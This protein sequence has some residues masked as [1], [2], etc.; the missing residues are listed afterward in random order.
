M[1]TSGLG[2]SQSNTGLDGTFSITN[3]P[4][5]DYQV[6]FGDP[7]CSYSEPNL[8]PGWF[9]NAGHQPGCH[10]GVG[11]CGAR[12]PCSARTTLTTG[13][14]HH[15]HSDRRRAAVRWPAY[16]WRRRRPGSA[17]ARLLGDQRRHGGYSIIDLPAGHYR[18]QF[19]SGCGAAGYKTQWWKDKPTGQAATIVTVTAAT[20]TT[21]IGAGAAEVASG[22]GAEADAA[23]PPAKAAAY[24]PARSRPTH[25]GPSRP[26][27]PD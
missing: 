21:G 26:R 8:A 14:V 13:R 19:S 18:V 22:P 3:L 15:R 24:R 4:P 23:D 16:A 27:S 25:E 1:Q 2:Y 20:A 11:G 12:R 17:A 6:L 9:Q 7:A 10:G 5:G